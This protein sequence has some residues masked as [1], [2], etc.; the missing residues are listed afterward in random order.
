MRKS[1]ASWPQISLVPAHLAP[2]LTP[3]Y[4]RLFAKAACRGRAPLFDYTIKDEST[5]QREA[6]H[7]QARTLCRSCAARSA[8]HNVAANTPPEER[9]G[10][11]AGEL[12][13]ADGQP[14]D[15]QEAA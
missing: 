2:L 5:E 12:Y 11:W 6:R 3:A 14:Q 7:H 1:K 8:C 9:R 15:H 10:I 13:G 4:S